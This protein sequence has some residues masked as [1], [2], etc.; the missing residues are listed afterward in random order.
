M[1]DKKI[2]CWQQ[3]CS[4]NFYILLVIAV[5]LVLN[6][7]AQAQATFDFNATRNPQFLVW[8]QSVTAV[9]WYITPNVS[10]NLTRIETNFHPV[11]QSG[12]QNRNV[13]V[14]LLTDRRAANGTLLRSA[15]FD[16]TTARGRLGGGS[17]APVMLT[18]G[19]TYFIGFRNVGGIGINTTNDAGAVNCGAC[20]YADNETS[21]EGQYQIRFGNDTPSVIDQPI[22]RLIGV[23]PPT[24]TPTP[25][26][27][28]TPTPT[29]VPGG[30]T[31]SNGGLNPRSTSESGVAAPAGGFFFSELQHNTGNATEANR[32][33]GFSPA[34]PSFRLADD[35]TISQ[36][37]TLNTVALYGFGVDNQTQNPFFFST[38]R[39]WNGIPEGIGSSIV[40][41][42]DTTNRFASSVDS[43]Y[44][45]ISNSV[46]PPPGS[47]PGSNTKIFR[48]MLTINTTLPAGTYWFDWDMLLPNGAANFAPSK[49]I[50]GSRGAA[51]DNA[52]QLNVATGVW[53]PIFDDGIPASAPDVFQDLPFDVVGTVAAGT[54]TPTPTPLATI[55]G[56]VEPN[57]TSGMAQTLSLGA[58]NCAIVD[59]RISP[60]ADVDYYRIDGVNAGSKINVLVDTGGDQGPGATSDNSLVDVIAANGTTIIET[61][62]DDGTGNGGDAT[63]ETERSSLVAGRTLTAGETYY[64]RVRAFFADSVINPYRLFVVVTPGGLP[65][66][67]VEGNN[68][69]ASAN[70]IV[71]AATA[72]GVRTSAISTAGDVDF[73]SVAARTGSLV[74]IAADQDQA[75]IGGTDVVVDLL[76]PDGTTVLLSIDNGFE[77]IGA[78]DGADFFILADG[79]YYVRVKT[80][81]STGTGTYDLMVSSCQGPS[82]STVS[83]SGRVVTPDGR[84][85]RNAVVSL[86]DAQGVRRT[87]TTSSFGLYSFTMVTSGQTYTVTVSS[88]RYRFTPQTPT[89]N[90]NV[91]NLDFTGLE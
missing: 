22:L 33:T 70:P 16:S 64:I 45:R 28:P 58:Q 61:D 3:D 30:C 47:A 29:P 34:R 75:R 10:L 32:I 91:T 24:P 46:V 40:F 7:A 15:V 69:P 13:T 36:P 18:A 81:G 19:T 84:G 42:N 66:P 2:T 62:D 20:L 67:E 60:Q 68:T 8:G 23:T 86:I 56:E 37:C 12:S 51:G 77:P 59:G 25:T 79:L 65:T 89:V 76:A 55:T 39:I 44:F 50:A 88:K 57:N 11:L 21:V 5:I 73:Y 54:P 48:I 53:T 71:T 17:F 38:L 80:F 63:V 35:F 26:A 83:I 6:T 87:A 4:Y 1:R 49:T 85:L 82:T 90:D 78:A 74:F 43:A 27:T 9:G 72:T 41:G 52:R 31:F 14:E